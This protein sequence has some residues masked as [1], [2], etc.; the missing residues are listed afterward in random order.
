MKGKNQ[1]SLKNILIG[2]IWVCSGQSNMEMTLGQCQGA[3]DDIKT[4]DLPKIRRIK[5]DRVQ[6]ATSAPA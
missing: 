6:V 2:D 1:L 5:L 4:A 3:A